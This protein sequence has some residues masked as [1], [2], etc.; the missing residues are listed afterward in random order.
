MMYTGSVI[1]LAMLVGVVAFAGAQPESAP[2]EG[3]EAEDAGPSRY[4]DY[5]AAPVH[6][7]LQGGLFG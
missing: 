3:A 1:F 6:V 5:D 7:T 4:V 2:G